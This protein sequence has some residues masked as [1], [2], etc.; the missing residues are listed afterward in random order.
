MHKHTN[1][2]IT[3]F[4]ALG[5]WAAACADSTISARNGFKQTEA[6]EPER[7]ESYHAT[8]KILKLAGDESKYASLAAVG[9]KDREQ[10]RVVFFYVGKLYNTRNE[11]WAWAKYLEDGKTVA[12]SE[13]EGPMPPNEEV[14]WKISWDK[15]GIVR[16]SR[17]GS[18]HEIATRISDPQCVQLVSGATARFQIE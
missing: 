1:A 17:A 13:A 10:N 14:R 5:V 7:T 6:C 11:Q 8:V 15:S 9:L 4:V 16:Y 3:A 12:E 2:S 18:N